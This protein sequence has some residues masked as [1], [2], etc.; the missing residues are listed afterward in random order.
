MTAQS[1]TD[2]RIPRDTFASMVTERLRDSIVDGTLPP[3]V[4]LSEVQ[5]ADRFGVSRSTIHEALQRLV[6][7][8]LLRSEPRRRAVVPVL[9]E[10]DVRDI[11]LAREAFE[12]SAV[13]HLVAT[14]KT[15]QAADELDRF[16]KRMEEAEAANDWDAVGRF[17][18]EFHT[19]LVAATGSERLQR[20]FNT[21]IAETRLCLGV[22]TAAETPSNL[23]DDHRQ[24]AI[25]IRERKP[26]MALAVLKKH[27]DNTIV[28]I[29]TQDRHLTVEDRK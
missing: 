4:Q 28:T 27:F 11:Y 24:I 29:E 1:V 23:V 9:T 17:D 5:L 20:M 7:E 12:S 2:T 13:Q 3:G 18:L 14:S 22:L 21:V 26:D 8:G 10:A 25:L 19:A 16:V 15:E 6:H